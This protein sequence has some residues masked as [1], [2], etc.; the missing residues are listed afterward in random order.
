MAVQGGQQYPNLQHAQPCVPV[1][2][3]LLGQPQAE[4]NAAVVQ[5]CGNSRAVGRLLK[6]LTL[7]HEPSKRLDLQQEE[8]LDRERPFIDKCPFIGKCPPVVLLL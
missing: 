3:Q 1:P 6:D 7:K 8:L 5:C 2:L 4:H